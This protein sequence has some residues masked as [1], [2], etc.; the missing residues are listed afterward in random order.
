[1]IL[2]SESAISDPTEMPQPGIC[3]SRSDIWD[4]GRSD[5][6]IVEVDANETMDLEERTGCK[7]RADQGTAEANDGYGGE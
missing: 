5:F 6:N 3:R 2:A 7:I 4:Y 1:M